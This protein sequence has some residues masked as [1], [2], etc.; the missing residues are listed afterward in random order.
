MKGSEPGPNEAQTE[1]GEERASRE[2]PI[3]VIVPANN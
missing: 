1:G 2:L 3:G